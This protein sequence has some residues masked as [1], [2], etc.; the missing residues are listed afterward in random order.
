MSFLINWRI[1]IGMLYGPELLLLFNEDM[2]VIISVSSVGEIK[3]VISLLF[4]RNSEKCLEEYRIFLLAI[5]ATLE[6]YSL[7]L[8]EIVMGSNEISRFSLT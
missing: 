4:L 8:L 6:K 3:N 5:F 7:N 2:H 1:F